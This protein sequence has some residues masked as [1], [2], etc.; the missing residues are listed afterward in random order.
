MRAFLADAE[1][2][3]YDIETLRQLYTASF[4]QVAHRLVSLRKPGEPGLPFGFLR[5]DA[6]GRLTKHFP[7][8]GL[9][10]PSSGHACPRWADL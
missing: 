8:P 2:Q 5:S 9:P 4:E 10:L 6:A 1:A 7:L 3:R